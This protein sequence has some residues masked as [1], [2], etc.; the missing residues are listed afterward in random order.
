MTEKV[1]K[2]YVRR[3]QKDYSMTFKLKVVEEVERGEIS[4]SAAKRKYGI[5]GGHTITVWLRKYGN[6]DWENQT[7]S[8]MPKSNE[9][10]I[11]ELE[12][13]VKLLEKQKKFLETQAERADK[14]AILFDMMIDIAE[15]EFNI[16]I[17]KK[18]LPEE[19]IDLKTNK[20]KR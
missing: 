10:K 8:N 1:R 9:Q 13:K 16:P 18:S 11:L 2:E 15:K 5:Q 3:T 19:L 6:F 20:K 12:Q 4:I 14:K 7:P 17:R